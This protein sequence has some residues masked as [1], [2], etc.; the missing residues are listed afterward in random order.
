MSLYLRANE[1]DDGTV[2]PAGTALDALA[3]TPSRLS[4]AQSPDV[5]V[6]RSVPAV[7][8]F[9]DGVE[10]DED[11]RHEDVVPGPAEILVQVHNAGS[12]PTTQPVR[13][14][15]LWAFADTGPPVL[16]AGFWTTFHAGALTVGNTHGGWTVAFDTTLPAGPAGAGHGVVPPGDPRVLRQAVTWP[17]AVAEHR[18]VGLLAVVTGADDPV[19]TDDS[20]ADLP[21][22]VA[23]LLDR[24]RRVA[25]REATVL[26]PEDDRRIVLRSTGLPAVP[27]RALARGPGFADLTAAGNPLGLPSGQL[28][29]DLV[30]TGTAPFNLTPPGANPFGVRFE[31]D[32]TTSSSPSTRPTPTSPTWPRCPG[33]RRRGDRTGA[34]GGRRPDGRRRPL[35]QR[36]A[37]RGGHHLPPAVGASP[38]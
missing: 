15:V 12:F 29:P 18:A 35:L 8:T 16:P 22:D 17:A 5:K 34:A 33:E 6:A 25:Y 38:W 4:P 37:G 23:G 2:R 11:V 13:V 32:R 9:L 24:E 28:A 10:F 27:V 14:A 7:G 31:L 21:L 20:I 3:P 19:D 26:H 30:L 1:A 36:R